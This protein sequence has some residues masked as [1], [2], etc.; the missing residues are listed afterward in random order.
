VI[1][2]STQLY[3]Y[4]RS[5]QHGALVVV[6]WDVGD[7]GEARVSVITSSGMVA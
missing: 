3:T 2:I 6:G 4:T 5:D 7:R 1:I